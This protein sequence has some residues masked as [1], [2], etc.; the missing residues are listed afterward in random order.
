MVYQQQPRPA[1]AC[2]GDRSIDRGLSGIDRGNDVSYAAGVL[3]LEPV[4]RVG[5]VGYRVGGEQLVEKCDEFVQR[6]GFTHWR[7]PGKGRAATGR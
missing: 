6:D 4:Q 5:V 1:G 7:P 3:H 2:T